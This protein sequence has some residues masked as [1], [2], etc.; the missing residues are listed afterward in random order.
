M[1]T[2]RRPARP[3]RAPRG[4]GRN[5]GVG[6]RPDSLR[7]DVGVAVRVLSR[8]GTRDGRRPCFDATL[9]RQRPALR[10]RPPVELRALRFT[11][12]TDPVRH[13]R[14]RRDTSGPLGMGREAPCRERRD[15][16]PRTRF[17]P[18]RPANH[19][20]GGR[21]GVPA[22]DAARGQPGH[23]RSLVRP[24]GRRAGHGVGAH[25]GRCETAR[26]E[27]RE[28]GSEG[29]RQGENPRPHER[30]RKTCRR[31]RRQAANR[32]GPAADRADRRT[33]PG[34]SDASPRTIRKG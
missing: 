25:R 20:H 10:R 23:P 2:G 33:G 11:R 14:L 5:P 19:G 29:R 15:S 24:H 27:G 21:A 32:P 26:Q 34:R 28:A 8:L 18:L 17:L 4:A 3:D 31:D 30:V 1:E 16:G 13:Q 6:T 9:G 22:G 12:T 7:A